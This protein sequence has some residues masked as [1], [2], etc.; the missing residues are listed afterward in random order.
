MLKCQCLRGIVLSISPLFPPPL[1]PLFLYPLFFFSPRLGTRLW[2][3][4]TG[5]KI[6]NN[7]TT[8]KVHHKTKTKNVEKNKSLFEVTYCTTTPSP[9]AL[10]NV[11]HDNYLTICMMNVDIDSMIYFS[12]EG[13]NFITVCPNMVL[14]KL[15]LLQSFLPVWVMVN[16]ILKSM[17]WPWPKQAS[18][19]P[20]KFIHPV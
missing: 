5:T 11:K 10:Y 12:T 15:K 20:E 2:T 7:K 14:D 1:H 19:F 4:R 9:L 6:S 16:V 18:L 8:Q 13:F 3:P 17:H